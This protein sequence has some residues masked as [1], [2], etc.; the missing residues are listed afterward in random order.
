MTN[1]FVINWIGP[2]SSVD[3][4]KSWEKS[5]NQAFDYNFYIVTGKQK[6]KKEITKYCGITNS[7][8]G[9]VYSRFNDKI[10]KVHKLCNEINIWIGCL[11]DKRLR[12]RENIELCETMIISYWQPEENIKKK[13]YYPASPV[14]MINRWFDINENLRV[15]SI[16][17][18]QKLSD[19]IIYDE[20]NKGIFG[21]E[22]LKKLVSVE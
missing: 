6:S 15:R 16:Y 22:S 3:Q 18:A 9:Y 11:T 19:V 17:P 21:A 5:Y 13:A 10:H 4:L 7:Q 8:K 1:T 12:V 2:F 14:V 20:L